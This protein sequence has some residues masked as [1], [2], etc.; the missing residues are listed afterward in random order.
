M[1]HAQSPDLPNTSPLVSRAARALPLAPLS[2]VLGALARDTLRK[3]P[4]ILR[5]MGEH[6][7][8]RFLID[9]LDL[10]F[11]L[12]M[13]PAAGPRVTAWRRGR[14]PQWDA[15]IAG[16]LSG[17]L[18]MLHGAADGDA[19]FFSGDLRI[20]GNTAA[21]LA[22]RNALDDAET[23]LSEQLARR[24]GPLAPLLRLGARRLGHVTGLA[25]H[26]RTTAEETA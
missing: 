4:Q 18:A 11:V 7:T 17:F 6:G 2:A 22:L 26:R 23:D 21:V 14:S 20:E 19:L 15:R 5:R 8:R 24:S 12:L 3:H 13:V 9:P 16:P 10:P 1:T 25:L